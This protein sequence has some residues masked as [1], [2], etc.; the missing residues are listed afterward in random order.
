[1]KLLFDQNL[2]HRLVAKLRDIFPESTHTRFLH[3]KE[4]SD[5]HIWEFARSNGFTVVTCDKDFA[6]LSFLRGSPPKIIWVRIGNTSLKE[7]EKIIRQ[8]QESIE[9]FGIHE[10]WRLLEIWPDLGTQS[11]CRSI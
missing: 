8:H 9:K 2:S 10:N 4:A 3:F 1:L 6:D 11:P 5:E 7:T